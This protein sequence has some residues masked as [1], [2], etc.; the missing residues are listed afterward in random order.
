ACPLA[1]KGAKVP[2]DRRFSDAGH[3]RRD[4]QPA[5]NSLHKNSDNSLQLNSNA[6]VRDKK[7]SFDLSQSGEQ[8]CVLS[9]YVREIS[10][11]TRTIIQRAGTFRRKVSCSWDRP[12]QAISPSSSKQ[13]D[14]GVATPHQRVF[15]YHVEQ[16]LPS[17]SLYGLERTLQS[18]GNFIWFFNSLRIGT[19]SLRSEFKVRG[20]TQIAAGKIARPLRHPI[21]IESSRGVNAR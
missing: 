7:Q 5:V 11:T 16:R 18:S 15:A 9:Q 20:G 19:A 21:W 13:E 3:R 6:I 2:I 8:S 1:K 4:F 10:I 14:D 17:L 12:R